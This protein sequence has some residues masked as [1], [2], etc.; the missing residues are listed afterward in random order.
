MGYTG[1]ARWINAPTTS[2]E[3][4]HQNIM[5]NHQGQYKGKWSLSIRSYRST[6]SSIP[7]YQ[8]LAERSMC[9]LT[10]NDNVFALLEDPAAPGHVDW[11]QQVAKLAI[12]QPGVTLP[13]PAHYRLTFPTLSPPGA[14]EQLLAQLR[15]RWVSV[16][17]TGAAA[18]SGGGQKNQGTGQ[19][20]SVEGHVYAIGT[21]WLVRAG[22]VLLAGGAVKG[23]F[24]EAEYLPLP[25]MPTRTNEYGGTD[26]PFLL[27]NLLLSVLP[28][29]PDARIVAVTIG[30]S[31]WEEMLWDEPDEDEEQKPVKKEEDDIYAEDDDQPATRKGDWEGVER[32]RRSAYLIIGALKQEGLL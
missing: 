13:P 27:S 16:R 9:T 4:I 25:T 24:L 32:D 21:D 29:V 23:M 12:E 7:G 18:S 10:M 20:L 1:L 6:L 22:N 26:L 8:V 15:A 3:L 28:N 5:R 2:I 19:Q 30:D 14:L 11:Q 31:Q 17:Q